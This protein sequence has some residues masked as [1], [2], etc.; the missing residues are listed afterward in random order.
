MNDNTKISILYVDDE[1]SL[2]N[3]VKIF[4]ERSSEIEVITSESADEAFNLLKEKRFD[5]IISDYLMPEIDGIEFL[6]EFR[7]RDKET[8]F[9]LFTG[10]G[11]EE[12]A[13]QAIENG[14]DFYV[15][16]GGEPVSQ[17]AE[18]IHK[19]KKKDGTLFSGL[20]YNN[21]IVNGTEVTGVRGAI[22]DISSLRQSEIRWKAIVDNAY[23]III[24]LDTLGNITFESKYTELILGYIPGYCTGKRYYEFIH[25]DDLEMVRSE[26]S[27]LNKKKDNRTQTEFRFKKAEGDY[28]WVEAVITSCT[29]IPGIEG[30]IVNARPLAENPS[31]G[32]INY[33]LINFNF[34][35]PKFRSLFEAL[36]QSLKLAIKFSGLDCGGIYLMNNETN[37]LDLKVSHGLTNKFVEFANSY[38]AGSP[39]TDLVMCGKPFY[40]PF[41]S[42]RSLEKEIREQ[43]NIR[44]IAIIPIISDNEVKGCLNVASHSIDD[45]P[46]HARIILET[47]ASYIGTQVVNFS[48]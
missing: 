45:V 36:D 34:K 28:I 6:K 37:S 7:K 26:F 10:K 30:I 24:I 23:D 8:P 22:L 27:L 9:I 17:F 38:S 42:Q 19:V 1:P 18:L 35:L 48:G 47:I 25:P 4:L 43:E 5:A 31:D 13:I 33:E 12:I 11:R 39:N 3:L 15:Q 29:G 16:K 32:D 44:A 20:I 46:S 40:I 21:P 14:A 2:L 41:P